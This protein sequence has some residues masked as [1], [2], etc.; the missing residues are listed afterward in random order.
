MTNIR[1]I[2]TDSVLQKLGAIH[3][4]PRTFLHWDT[5]FHL[6]MA[7][8]LSAQCTDKMV[9]RLSPKLFE[10]YRTPEDLAHAKIEELQRDIH[11]CGHFRVKAKYLKSASAM[12]L[13]K[14]VGEVPG[15]MEELLMLPGVGRK[16][17]A[18]I[19]Y[20]VFKKNDGIAVDTHV[21]RVARRLGLS[22][23]KTQAR[24]ERDLMEQTPRAQWGRLH[25]LLIVHG[26]TICTARNR[27]CSTCM[28]RE[29]C[30]S[31]LVR[32]K[33]DLAH[34]ARTKIPRKTRR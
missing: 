5:P 34:D 33:K 13:E 25:T 4:P 20:A 32:S 17:A 11:S 24:I 23:G 31:S 27:K 1:R 16:T 10:K 18:V 12:L 26:R 22:K 21:F 15:T 14:F 6:L 9:N 7:T 3:T 19:L 28:F 30:P 2:T 29:E 8:I